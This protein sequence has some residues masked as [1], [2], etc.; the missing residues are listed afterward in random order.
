MQHVRF[1]SPSIMSRDLSIF[2]LRLAYP[3]LNAQIY[4]ASLCSCALIHRPYFQLCFPFSL[5]GLY[6]LEGRAM[7]LLTVGQYW[8]K[9]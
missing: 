3:F 2:P 7:S 4:Q 9:T 5:V 6:W 8:L 1:S